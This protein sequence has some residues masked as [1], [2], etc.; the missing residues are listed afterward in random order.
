M[1]ESEKPRF[2]G[3][4]KGDAISQHTECC[5]ALLQHRQLESPHRIEQTKGQRQ[6][7]S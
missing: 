6:R 1:K 7:L 4:N 3:Q 5:G 2:Y